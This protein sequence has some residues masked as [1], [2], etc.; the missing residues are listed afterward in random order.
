MADEKDQAS[1]GVLVWGLPT[2]ESSDS[3]LHRSFLSAAAL[4][5]FSGQTAQSRTQMLA[6][7]DEPEDGLEGFR[8]LL[9]AGFPAWQVADQ[10]RQHLEGLKKLPDGTPDRDAA[11][12]RT[13]QFLSEIPQETK[14]E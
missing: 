10:V 6:K 12:R 3:R 13:E 11:I 1:E 4:N 9:K 8:G 5:P 14:G 7:S 2:Q